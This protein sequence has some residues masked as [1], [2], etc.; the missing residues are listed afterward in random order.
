MKNRILTALAAAACATLVACSSVATL[1]TDSNTALKDL[2]A[3]RQT[4]DQAYANKDL[5]G[6]TKFHAANLTA[7]LADGSRLDR[8]GYSQYE[9][10]NVARPDRESR[11]NLKY[12]TGGSWR[13]FGCGAHSTVEGT[14]WHNV[15]STTDYIERMQDG[16]DVAIDTHALSNDARLEEALFTGLRL[17]AGLDIEAVGARYGVDV[18]GRYGRPLQPFVDGR[19]LLR[20]GPRLRLTREGMLL[21]NEIMS[22]FV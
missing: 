7:T 1:S 15:A 10:S 13:G 5:A 22:V 21:A 20:E 18:W 16:R 12:W 9:I 11:H 4:L 6:L 3:V 19:L 14:R 17:T 8:A 2:T